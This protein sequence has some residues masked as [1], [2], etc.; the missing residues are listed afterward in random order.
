M[1][2][3]NSLEFLTKPQ[4]ADL[5]NDDVRYVYITLAGYKNPGIAS[6][7][8]EHFLVTP[9][10]EVRLNPKVFTHWRE[11]K[12]ELLKKL[13]SQANL[14][15]KQTLYSI[16]ELGENSLIHYSLELPNTI[17]YRDS[18]GRSKT[19]SPIEGNHIANK[20]YVDRIN[21]YGIFYAGETAEVNEFYYG[22]TMEVEQ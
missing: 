19:S 16:D 22:E 1:S 2:E 9:S 8:D 10:G 20:D 5:I 11:I 18:D 6:F 15:N 4:R 12:D 7:E 13:D 3:R 17:M 21:S 14:K